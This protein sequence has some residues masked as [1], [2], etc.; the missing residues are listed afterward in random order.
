[1]AL[2]AVSSRGQRAFDHRDA[3]FVKSDID[4]GV[5]GIVS[6][7]RFNGAERNAAA[8]L[9]KAGMDRGV[10]GIV[11]DGRFNGAERNAAAA[12]VKAGMDRGVCGAIPDNTPS[13]SPPISYVY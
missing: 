2:M 6:D 5:C 13:P 12:L 3:G 10:C 11:S 7:G 1:M 4:R 8:A 9:V